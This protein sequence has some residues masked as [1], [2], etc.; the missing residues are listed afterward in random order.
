METFR[1][2]LRVI[3]R[4]S[5]KKKSEIV[6]RDWISKEMFYEDLRRS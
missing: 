1:D 3:S 6:R 5:R 2:L 4:S